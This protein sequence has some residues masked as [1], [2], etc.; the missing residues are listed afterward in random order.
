MASV[1]SSDA[2]TGITDILRP[3]IATVVALLV[4][5]VAFCRALRYVKRDKEHDQRP[6]KTR[7]DFK[8]MTAEE[9]WQIIHYVQSQEFPWII[10]KALS[11]ALFKYVNG[12][13][14]V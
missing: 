3:R 13:L 2:L 5:Y 10:K 11:F 9:A 6:F 7:E 14:E 4:G 12:I 1:M 8:K